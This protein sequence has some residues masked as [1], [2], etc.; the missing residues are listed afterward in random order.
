MKMTSLA[1]LTGFVLLAQ[2]CASSR[3]IDTRHFTR[4]DEYHANLDIGG[5]R[6]MLD[7]YIV[8]FQKPFYITVTRDDRQGMGVDEA[9]RVAERYIKPRGCTDPLVRRAD[10]DRA[11]ADKTQWMI[12]IEC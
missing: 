9:A 8:M 7:A 4:F 12:G 3:D 10:L 6:Y 5:H 1:Y 2:G 11:N